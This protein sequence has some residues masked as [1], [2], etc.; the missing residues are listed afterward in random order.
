MRGEAPPTAPKQV[1]T[2]PSPYIV[3]QMQHTPKLTIDTTEAEKVCNSY[4]K[5][6][7]I[8]RFN[9]FWPKPLDLF[10]WILTKWSLDCE[11]HLY[12]KWFFI[13]KFQS[14]EVRDLVI[15]EGPWFWGSSGLFI[16]PRFPE[17]D[18]NSFI[19]SKIPVWVRLHNLPIHFWDQKILAS[20][21]NA[22]GRYIKMDTQRIDERIFTFAR[23][24]VEVDLSKGLPGSIKLNHKDCS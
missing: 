14:S 15:Q 1:R 4:E 13:V 20:I 22:I 5:L 17:F 23:I 8:C 6:A 10:H 3:E 7:I 21:G 9:G 16:T 2:E 19:V 24:C 11:I 12:S 18:A